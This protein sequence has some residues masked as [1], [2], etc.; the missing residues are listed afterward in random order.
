MRECVCVCACVYVCVCVRALVRACFAYAACDAA[1]LSMAFDCAVPLHHRLSY[2]NPCVQVT[3]VVVDKAILD[4]MPYDLKVS[5]GA[6]DLCCSG[7][8][9]ARVLH[10]SFAG[11]LHS[12]QERNPQLAIEPRRSYQAQAIMQHTRTHSPPPPTRLRTPPAT[13]VPPGRFW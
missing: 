3:V 6:H 7:I 11:I 10:P 2:T 12:R 4:L 9:P 1:M 5:R 8:P 13:P